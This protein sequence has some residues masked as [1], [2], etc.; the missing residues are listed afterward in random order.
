MYIYIY[1]NYIYI[2]I[3]Q[4][5]S[6]LMCCGI[7]H[8]T[9]ILSTSHCSDLSCFGEGARPLYK[10]QTVDNVVGAG[11]YLFWYTL[12][13]NTVTYDVTGLHES[14]TCVYVHVH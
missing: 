6:P 2:R 1:R 11:N 8:N 14:A 12:M 5:N 7:I 13:F 10:Q 9:V 3:Q 4:H